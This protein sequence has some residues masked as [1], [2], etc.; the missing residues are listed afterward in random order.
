MG[1]VPGAGPVVAQKPTSSG[2]QAL[3]DRE[4]ALADFASAEEAGNLVA[5][6]EARRRIRRAQELLRACGWG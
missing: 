5:A 4:L 3:A 2:T 6:A 1:R